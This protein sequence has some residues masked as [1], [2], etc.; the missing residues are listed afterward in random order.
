MKKGDLVRVKKMPNLDTVFDYL[1]SDEGPPIEYHEEL[2]ILIDERP[3]EPIP[4]APEYELFHND[5]EEDPTWRG[6]YTPHEYVVY[7]MGETKTFRSGM[8]FPLD[9]D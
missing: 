5:P 3:P 2:G 4:D 7:H 6:F 8:I 9:E 1:H